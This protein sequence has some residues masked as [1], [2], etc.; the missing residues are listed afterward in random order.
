[1]LLFYSAGWCPP[2][3]EFLQVLKDFYNEVNIDSKQIEVVFI[4]SDNDEQG[5][6]ETYAQMPWLTFPFSS[7][8]HAELKEKFDIIGVPMVLVC[9]AE[10]GF[11]V[12]KKGRKDIFD[13]GVRAISSWREHMPRAMEVAANNMYGANVVNEAKAAAYAEIKRKFERGDDE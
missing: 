4:S 9:D 11:M 8:K 5:F 1:M 6:K 7:A 12:T 2:C 10:T 13:I 3:N